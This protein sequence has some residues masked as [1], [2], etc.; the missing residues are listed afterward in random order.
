MTT[1]TATTPPKVWTVADLCALP[2]DGMERWIIRGQLREQPLAEWESFKNNQRTHRFLKPLGNLYVLLE[3]WGEFR[4]VV[5][6]KAHCGKLGVHFPDRGTMIYADLVFVSN[7]IDADI[8]D[9]NS[10]DFVGVPT[11]LVEILSPTDVVGL[12]H[13][14]IREYDAAGVP[15]VWLIDTH[16]QTLRINRPGQPVEMFN[17]SHRMPEHPAIPGFAPAVAE[18]FE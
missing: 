4:T 16:S 15:I 18:L 10:A 12:I 7:E 9:R 5:L 2:N 1:A 3:K 14:R 17:T 8:E 13:E 11:L 6:G